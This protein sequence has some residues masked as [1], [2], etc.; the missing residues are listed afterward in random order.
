MSNKFTQMKIFMRGCKI[1][2][3]IYPCLYP[4][5]YPDH[6]CDSPVIGCGVRT[7]SGQKSKYEGTAH[8]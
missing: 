5:K 2:V 7:L 3:L 4:T 6:S 8:A 1:S